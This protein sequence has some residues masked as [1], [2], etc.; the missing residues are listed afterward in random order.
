MQTTRFLPEGENKHEHSGLSPFLSYFLASVTE[1]RASGCSFGAPADRVGGLDGLCL[2]SDESEAVLTGGCSSG[3][4]SGGE[5]GEAIS[6]G[7]LGKAGE[8]KARWV[9]VG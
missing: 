3:G 1:V 7:R 2:T 8:M 5:V 9:E 4:A 6:M